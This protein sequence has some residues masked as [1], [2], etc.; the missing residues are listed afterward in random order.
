ML[1][2]WHLMRW[3]EVDPL[4]LGRVWLSLV[5]FC[6]VMSSWLSLMTLEVLGLLPQPQ[7]SDSRPDAEGVTAKPSATHQQENGHSSHAQRGAAS[8]AWP[9][10]TT[11]LWRQRDVRLWGVLEHSDFCPPTQNGVALLLSMESQWASINSD[12]DF[13]KSSSSFG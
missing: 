6:S 8:A 13:H 7:K 10:T 2:K 11:C 4:C 12:Q 3:L 5:S 9:G 1:N